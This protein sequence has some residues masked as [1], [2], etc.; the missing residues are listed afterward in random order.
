[1]VTTGLPVP[2]FSYYDANGASTSV[3]ANIKTVRIRVALATATA[4]GRQL[5]YDTRV[6]LRPQS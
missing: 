3:A 6:T 4:P 1:V 2:V 5:V